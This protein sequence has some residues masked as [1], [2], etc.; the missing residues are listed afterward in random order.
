MEQSKALNQQSQWLLPWQWI[1]PLFCLLCALLM[2][3]YQSRQL[4]EQRQ[5]QALQQLVGISGQ[6]RSFVEAE[7]NTSLYMSLGLASHIRASDGKLSEKEMLFLLQNL[8]EQ[9]KHIRNIGLAPDNILTL[10]YPVQGNER[11]LGL[12]YKT[13]RN[14]GLRLGS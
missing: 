1:V 11:A 10:I 14:N 9:G 4:V 13:Y 12:N 7:L 3:E 8:L 5:N 6:L 2:T